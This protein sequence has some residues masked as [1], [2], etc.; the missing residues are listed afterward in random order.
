METHSGAAAAPRTVR[1]YNPA[2]F[3]WQGVNPDGTPDEK[4][5]E[6]LTASIVETIRPSKVILFGSA[7]RGEMNGESDFDFLV[8]ADHGYENRREAEIAVLSRLPL[9]PRAVDITVV[10]CGKMK[11]KTGTGR[12]FM[13]EAE[14][15][16]RVL[17]DAGSF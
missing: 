5:I 9:V 8:V 6:E 4:M 14:E 15:E 12:L 17:Y 3:E 13:M 7:A 1:G 10:G 11:N 2:A 16:G